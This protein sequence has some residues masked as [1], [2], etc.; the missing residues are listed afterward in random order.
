MRAL[1]VY[2]SMFGNTQAVGLAIADGLRSVLETEAIEVA[3][4]P[5]T[6]PLDVGL[7]IV[8]GPTHA[9]GLTTARSRSEA[10]RRVGD[11]LVSQGSGIRE[12]LDALAPGPA[13]ISAAAFDTRI[14]GPELL[15]GS[16]AK[17]AAKRLRTLGF[18]VLPAVSFIVSGPASEPFDQVAAAELDRAR[19]WGRTLGQA[20]GSRQPAVTR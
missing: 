5:P 3:E 8:G 4:A 9:H 16:A 19:A 12:W 13:P 6:L 20:I 15:L 18:R 7:L 17:G 1:V 11:R 2:E 14:K 10:A